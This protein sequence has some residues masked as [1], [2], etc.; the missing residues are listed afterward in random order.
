MIQNSNLATQFQDEPQQ[1]PETVVDHVREIVG[2][3][4]KKRTHLS[5][6]GISKKC[7]VSEPTLRRIMSGKVKTSPQVTTL[8]D[9][10]TYISGTTSV[11]NIV[12][13][14]PGPIAEFFT[15]AMPHLDEFDQ[16]YSNALNDELQDSVKYL[17]YKLS[18]NH[19]GVREEKIRELY[20]NHGIQLLKEMMEK[21][22][23]KE[24][25]DGACRATARSFAGSHAQFVRNFKAVAD[26]IK[27]DK[28]RHRKPLNP[29]FVNMSD[30]ISPEAYEQIRRLQKSLNNKIR[31]ILSSE[32]SKGKIPFFYICAQDT[33]D[34]KSA[35]ELVESEENP[36]I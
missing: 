27:P 30:S 5:I 35:F 33:L 22:Y 32:E 16:E 14:Y 36:N 10:L 11:R 31:K 17:I 9:I 12:E 8:L 28:F 19:C 15:S 23:I 4:L 29:Y 26:F 13:M 34:L 21:G 1:S 20:G 24:D 6:N 7:A 2:A 25:S 3:Y 18:L